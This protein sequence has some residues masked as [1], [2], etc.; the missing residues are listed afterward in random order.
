MQTLSKT[1]HSIIQTSLLILVLAAPSLQAENLQSIEGLYTTLAEPQPTN[2][3]EKIEVLEF[4]WYG[5]PHCYTFEP[6][7]EKWQREKS[8]YIDF[9]RIPAV[10]G[11]HWID[12][13]K[14]YYSAKILNSLEQIHGPLFKAIHEQKSKIHDQ[15]SLRKFFEKQGINSA[16]FSNAYQSKEVDQALKIAYSLGK[17]YKITGVPAIIINGKYKTSISMAGSAEKT[18]QVINTLAALEQQNAEQ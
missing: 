11:E 7:L 3:G 16:D 4:F 17:N 18:I 5:C 8:E 1:S 6:A 10:L 14:A 2:T 13:A 12:H 9:I 15:E